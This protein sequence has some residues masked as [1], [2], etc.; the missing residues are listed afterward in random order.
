M[1]NINL[2]MEYVQMYRKKE[3][4]TLEKEKK[5]CNKVCFYRF[6]INLFLNY[7]PS[8]KQSFFDI[9]LSKTDEIFF[10]SAGICRGVLN[11][12]GFPTSSG[13]VLVEK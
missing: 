11:P 13:L 2:T 6:R 9:G 7:V 4:P 5:K 8:H 12:M 10:F 1:N 3:D